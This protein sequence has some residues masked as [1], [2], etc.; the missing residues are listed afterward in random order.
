MLALLL[1]AGA[2]FLL[3][4]GSS[5]GKVAGASVA[6]AVRSEVEAT[7]TPAP[8][9]TSEAAGNAVVRPEPVAAAAPRA[10][11]AAQIL[12]AATASDVSID[13]E[14][15]TGTAVAAPPAGTA[16]AARADAP[17]AASAVSGPG[18]GDPSMV[19]GERAQ[20]LQN[21]AP[22]LVERLGQIENSVA[23]AAIDLRR[24]LVFAHEAE[25]Y[26]DLASVAKI[27][28]MLALLED[29]ERRRQLISEDD[30]LL[31]QLM[32]QWS[33]NSAT[34]VVWDRLGTAAQELLTA[35]G[36]SPGVLFIND[37][38]GGGTGNAG[39]VA[40]LFREIVEGERLS[41][42]VRSD[43]MALLDG[44][45]A[46]QRW[47]LS[48]GLPADGPRVGLKNGWYP[49][50]DGWLVHTAGYV[51][52]AAGEPDYVVVILSAGHETLDDGVALVEEVATE[53]HA[54]LRPRAGDPALLRATR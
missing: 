25:T 32:I 8:A 12:D 45:A 22:Q 28:L 38:W 50:D 39:G 30:Q 44:V 2:S 24:E 51:V 18:T 13:P 29:V 20:A 27:P 19:G 21:L 23:I 48:A 7:D 41:P 49:T 10:S 40:R 6:T 42:A 33:D 46:V 1:G 4:S 31:L 14:A 36:V 9:R 34:G 37:D 5:D 11:A 54:A 52:N 16:E 3:D 35:L 17:T 43:A 26:Y 15:P 53:L 47:G